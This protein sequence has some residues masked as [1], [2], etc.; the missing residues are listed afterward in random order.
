MTPGFEK[1]E[2]GALGMVTVP[3]PEAEEGHLSEVLV[4]LQTPRRDDLWSFL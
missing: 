4:G 1:Q 2:R 3:V